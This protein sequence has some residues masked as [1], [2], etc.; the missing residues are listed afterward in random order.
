MKRVIN[1]GNKKQ[2]YEDLARF[3]N[4]HYESI[5]IEFTN[6]HLLEVNKSINSK[7]FTKNALYVHSSILWDIMQPI[8]S[9]FKHHSHGLDPKLIIDT[10]SLLSKT[11]FVYESYSNRYTFLVDSTS[12]YESIAIV[13]ELN[14]GLK[15]DRNANINKL[16]TIF[17]KDNLQK[18]ISHIPK[19]KIIFKK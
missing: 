7:L 18:K 2:T 5:E 6:I 11:F 19:E 14:A 1:V 16:V 17:P 8:G 12:E 4:K 15:N 10:L 13:I 3:K 9:T